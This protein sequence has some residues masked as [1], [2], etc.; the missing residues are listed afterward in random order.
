MKIIAGDR[1][2]TPD[3]TLIRALRNAHRWTDAM[4]GGISLRQLAQN[5]RH[6]E[7]YI[8]RIATLAGLSPTIQT[9]IMDGLAPIDLTLEVLTRRP[10]PLDWR[11]QER[12]FTMD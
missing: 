7:R 11:E 4:S 8:A 12:L 5:V 1:Q 6:T 2:P 9:A 10:I 3:A